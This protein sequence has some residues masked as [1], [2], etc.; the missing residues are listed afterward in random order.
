MIR[1]YSI[2]RNPVEIPTMIT[3][4]SIIFFR[5]DDQGPARRVLRLT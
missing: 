1:V 2:M 5:G 3:A 4:T